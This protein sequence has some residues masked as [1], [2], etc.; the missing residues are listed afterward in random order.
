M[1]GKVLFVVL[2]GLCCAN[3]FAESGLK[4]LA[5][6]RN[7]VQ[8][9]AMNV[10]QGEVKN[11]RHSKWGG[12]AQDLIGKIR[13]SLL[14]NGA[15]LGSFRPQ[16]MLPLFVRFFLLVHAFVVVR[17][18]FSDW[19]AILGCTCRTRSGHQ[20]N[21][22][23]VHEKTRYIGHWTKGGFNRTDIVISMQTAE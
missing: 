16:Q 7:D 4:K 15:P 1:L 18:N 19:S 10:L 17:I 22:V 11:Q 5:P 3:F 8:R 20:Y 14:L 13:S 21:Y 23:T 6:I 2:L 9:F 12:K